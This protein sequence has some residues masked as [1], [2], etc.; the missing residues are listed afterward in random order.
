MDAPGGWQI[1]QGDDTLVESYENGWAWSVPVSKSVRHFAVMVDPTLSPVAGRGQLA[2]VYNGELGRTR[3]FKSLLNGAELHGEPWGRDASPYS[4]SRVGESGIVLAGDAASFVDPLSSYGVKKALA[5]AWLAAVVVNTSLRDP[6]LAGAALSLH[7]TRE[8]AIVE[9]LRR[10]AAELSREAAGAH[11]HPFWRDRAAL[12]APAA[13]TEPDI[14]SLR[15]DAD[16][17]AAFESIRRAP[18]LRLR[19]AD[20]LVRIEKAV[21]HENRIVLAPHLRA[22]AFPDGIRYLRGI[23]LTTIVALAPAHDQV[24]DLFDAYNRA[25]PPVALPDFLG[26]LSVLVGKGMME[27][28]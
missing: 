13:S 25:A 15:A 22:P 5:S 23:D 8:Q 17:L 20:G 6:A 10:Q 4:A 28:A 9:S 1:E 3:W 19:P 11:D 27:Q 24:P 21:V 18:V 12:D 2:A 16:V 7:A 26:A 14:A